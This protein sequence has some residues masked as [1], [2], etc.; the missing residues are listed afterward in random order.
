MFKLTKNKKIFTR[1][2]VRE[3]ERLYYMNVF[4]ENKNGV[5]NMWIRKKENPKFK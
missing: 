5:S 1:K 3:A 2:E 4:D